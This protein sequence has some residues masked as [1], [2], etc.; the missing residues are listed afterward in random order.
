M[1]ETRISSSKSMLM[2][3]IVI[4]LTAM[5]WALYYIEVSFK[6]LA[7]CFII[8]ILINYISISRYSIFFLSDEYI[9]I[10]RPFRVVSNTVYLKLDELTKVQFA[11]VKGPSFNFFRS[12]DGAVNISFIALSKNDLRVFS[13]FLRNHNIKTINF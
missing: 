4:T 13:Q 2:M 1:K 12:T 8:S 6:S 5:L 10:V 9:K 11:G 7:I 3:L